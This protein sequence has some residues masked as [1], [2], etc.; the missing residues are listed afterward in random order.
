M[1]LCDCQ[2]FRDHKLCDALSEPGMADLTADVDF[3]YITQC[4]GDKGSLH[5]LFVVLGSADCR[6][7]GQQ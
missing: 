5:V 6:T 4:V 3:K 1:C 2:A 7:I